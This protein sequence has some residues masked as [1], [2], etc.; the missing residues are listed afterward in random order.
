M[1]NI[2]LYHLQLTIKKIITTLEK[3]LNWA[4]KPTFFHRQKFD[5]SSDLKINHCILLISLLFDCGTA[6]YLH[7]I[8]NKKK[9]A[10]PSSAFEISNSKFF[11]HERTQKIFTH[12]ISKCNLHEKVILREVF[13]STILFQEIIC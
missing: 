1:F 11:I 6:T 9:P 12:T 2:L 4:I 8:M 3:Q 13:C 5:S 7:S 10:F